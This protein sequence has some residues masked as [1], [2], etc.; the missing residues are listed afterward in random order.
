MLGELAQLY[1]AVFAP[2]LFMLLCGIVVIGYEWRILHRSF[3]SRIVGRFGVLVLGWAI[4]FFTLR[5]LPRLVPTL[6]TISTDVL[7]SIGLAV[8]MSVIW[9]VWRWRAWGPF[10]PQ[11]SAIL[12]G[13]TV[14]HFLI[15]LRWAISS[16]VIYTLTPAGYLSFVDRR[17]LPV[18]VVPIGMVVSRSLAGAHTWAQSIAG[19]LLASVVVLAMTYRWRAMDSDG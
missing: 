11:F 2:E 12:V 4:A 18:L 1:S 3:S 13:I 10:V 19:F 5:G 6:G 9:L 8:G 16:H 15:T 17:F 7:G 14:I